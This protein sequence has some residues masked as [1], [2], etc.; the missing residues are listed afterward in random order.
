MR[1]PEF[2]QTK[3]ILD[4]NPQVCVA[5]VWNCASNIGA[6]VLQYSRTTTIVALLQHG[7][8]KKT[9][10]LHVWQFLLHFGNM[11][12]PSPFIFEMLKPILPPRLVCWIP[13]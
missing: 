3:E 7:V 10:L 4:R 12:A 1:C 9:G 11:P 2:I 13:Q 8:E 5:E 6:T